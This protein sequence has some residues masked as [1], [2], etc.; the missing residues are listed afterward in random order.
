M[1]RNYMS[2][3]KHNCQGWLLTETVVAL[4]IL[5]IIGTC[6]FMTLDSAGK[7]NRYEL[8]RQR[9]LAAGQGHLDSIA[10]TG[11]GIDEDNS[12]RLWPGVNITVKRSAGSGDWQGLRL[13]RV[14]AR[15]ESAGKMV[16]VM[17]ARYLAGEG[18]I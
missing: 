18:D 12:A 5:A 2:N 7:Y 8:A 1:S 3:R 17:Q 9:C 14:R 13:V 16:E 15:T 11:V 10:V 6:L 4:G